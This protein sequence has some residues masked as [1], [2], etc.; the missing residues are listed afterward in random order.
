MFYGSR[1]NVRPLLDAPGTATASVCAAEPP[2]ETQPV[3]PESASRSNIEKGAMPLKGKAKTD[4]QRGYMRRKRAGLPT[5]TP[6]PPKPKPPDK[7]I[8]ER[9]CSFC[10]ELFDRRA[11]FRNAE[12]AICEKCVREA[13]S[14]FW[15]STAA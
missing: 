2:C 1:G 4:Y 12:G 7:P 8:R 14:A 13:V 5:A 6:R 15:P 11:L 3:M 9:H 10:Y